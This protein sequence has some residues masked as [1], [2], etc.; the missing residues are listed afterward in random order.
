L[1]CGEQVTEEQHII[2]GRIIFPVGG[3]AELA[4]R[5]DRSLRIH[6]EKMLLVGQ[7]EY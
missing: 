2:A 6:D 1:Q 3:T 7:H 5:A 4:V